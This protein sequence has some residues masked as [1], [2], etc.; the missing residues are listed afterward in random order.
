VLA[1]ISETAIVNNLLWVSKIRME[2][3]GMKGDYENL[4]EMIEMIEIC[5]VESKV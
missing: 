5:D 4:N 1:F 3:I 2:M